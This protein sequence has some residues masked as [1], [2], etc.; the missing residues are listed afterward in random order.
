MG[1]MENM[2]CDYPDVVDVNQLNNMLGGNFSKKLL[3]R[4]LR[5]QEIKNRKI[6]RE[7]RISKRNVIEYLSK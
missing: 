7:Y 4:L 3:Y 1:L 6:G 2:F 5:D